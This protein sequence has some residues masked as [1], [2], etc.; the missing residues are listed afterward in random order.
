MKFYYEA[1]SDVFCDGEEK[2]VCVSSE[3]LAKRDVTVLEIRG[4]FCIAI[5]ANA[6][7]ELD[8]L[9]MESNPKEVIQKVFVKDYL[10]RKTKKT[11]RL[12]LQQELEE[13]CKEVKMIETLKKFS[14]CDDEMK[15]MFDKF[16]ELNN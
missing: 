5:I 14:K 2:F 3:E 13:K 15:A 16:E 12:L 9:L 6:M 8:A 11:K 7:D 4:K 1:T 10:D